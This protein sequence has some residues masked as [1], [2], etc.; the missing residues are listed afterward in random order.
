MT[1]RKSVGVVL[2]EEFELLDVFGPLEMLGLLPEHFELLLVAEKGDIVASTQGPRSVLDYRFDNS[3]PFDILLLPG[4]RGTRREVD[5]PVMMGWLRAQAQ[6]AGYICSVCTGS[7]LL[8][9][10]GLLDG[11]RATTNKAAFEWVASQGERVDWQKQARWVEDGRYFTSSGVSA[12]M[13]MSLALIARVLD[14]QTAQQVAT[15]AEYE[16]H[17]DP[18]RDPFASVYGLA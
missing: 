9:R 16:W 5:N 13:D 17:R 4:G 14:P 7:A 1:Q 15:W 6:S 8:A 3:P 10:A 12:G 2:F 18:A 11:Q